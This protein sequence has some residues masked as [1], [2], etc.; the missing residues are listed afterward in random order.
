VKPL[1][2]DGVLDI[3]T[4]NWSDFVLGEVLYANGDAFQTRHP[5]ELFDE[6][7]YRGGQIWAHNGGKF[8]ALWAIDMAIKRGLKVTAHASGSRLVTVEIAD[9]VT[10]R[11]SYALIP[12]K[13]SEVASFGDVGVKGKWNH[14]LTTTDMNAA[15]VAEL[16]DYLHQDCQVL[17]SSLRGFFRI[18][19]ELGMVLRPTIGA[20]AWKTA[21]K[22]LEL[23]ET[24]VISS[25]YYGARAGYYGGRCQLF[26]P[27]LPEGQAWHMYD[28]T[29]AYPHALSSIPIP[30]GERF[31]ISGTRARQAYRIE[32]EGIFEATVTVAADTFIPPLPSRLPTRIAYPT[33]TFRG[34]WTGLELRAAE[35]SG[36]ELVD[37]H[38]AWVWEDSQIVFAPFMHHFFDYRQKVGKASPQGIAIK[39]LMNSLTGKLAQSPDTET[40]YVNPSKLPVTCPGGACGGTPTKCK[41][42]PDGAGGRKRPCC[43]HHCSRWCRSWRALG[44]RIWAAPGWRI[45]GNARPEW[46]AYLTAATRVELRRQL[47]DDGTGGRSVL[48]CDTDSCYTTRPRTRNIGE[49]LGRWQYDGRKFNWFALAPKAYCYDDEEGHPHQRAKGLPGL[50]DGKLSRAQFRAYAAGKAIPARRGVH[51]FKSACA[52][53]G[54]TVFT[55]REL[56]RVSRPPDGW[57]GDRRIGNGGLTYPVDLDT[58]REHER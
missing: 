4:A 50:V 46:A 2:I 48:Y 31:Y 18:A 21:A 57:Y 33:G 51:S 16:G 26:R 25:R 39:F 9:M 34:C 22:M 27:E 6:L 7:L 37:V 54:D 45:S 24:P 8:D 20:T 10:L 35:E 36:A 42:Y 32:R 17:L 23:D 38:G 49:G 53:G 55:R 47:T 15:Q 44:P 11:D 5:D 52:I 14:E 40:V 13:L 56:T 58:L 1:A 41:R 43:D 28:L 29:A 3:E 12:I 19:D 30:V